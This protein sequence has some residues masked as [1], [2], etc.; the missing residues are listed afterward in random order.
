VRYL[1]KLIIFVILVELVIQF[2]LCQ[3]GQFTEEFLLLVYF[4]GAY[5]VNHNHPVCVVLQ[6]V[7]IFS[8]LSTAFHGLHHTSAG[9]DVLT[10]LSAC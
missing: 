9:T 3:L 2:Y 8:L 4:I 1:L 6:R 7:C 10:C 5:S